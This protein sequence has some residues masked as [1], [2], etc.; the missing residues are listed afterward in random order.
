MARVTRQG[1]KTIEDFI[2]EE[3]ANP[4][5][6]YWKGNLTEDQQSLVEDI[7][8]DREE[9]RI[10]VYTQNKILRFLEF[11]TRPH[12]ITPNEADALRW[13]NDDGEP[14]FRKKV[15][16]P[17]FEPFSALRDGIDRRRNELQ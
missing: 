8:K 6:R 7:K 2:D 10:Q 14:V 12:V 11:G 5:Q 17:G 15:F 3:L 9:G 1:R 4:I 16:H 13:F